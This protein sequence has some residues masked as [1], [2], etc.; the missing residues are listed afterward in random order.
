M[1]RV[2]GARRAERVLKTFRYI[3]FEGLIMEKGFECCVVNQRKIN[4]DIQWR[5]TGRV[6]HELFA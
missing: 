6:Q 1:I 4:R 5:Y 3:K 2:R